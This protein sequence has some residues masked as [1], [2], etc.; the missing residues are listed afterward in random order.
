MSKSLNGI[1]VLDL[2]RIVSAPWCA[3]TLGD[4]G[5]DVIKI[6]RPGRGDDLRTY[7]PSFAHDAQGNPTPES[8]HYLCSN[9]NK[10]SVTIDISKPA[11]QE[12]IRRLA[13]NSDVLIENYKVGDL[14]RYGI[15]YE[16][17]RAVNPNLIY[18]SITGFGQDGPYAKQPGYD[19]AFQG[20]SG[21]M[22]VTGEPQGQPQRVGVFI[23]DEMTGLY[24]AI[25]IL[26]ALRH[27]DAG[28]GGQYIDLA[29][30]DVAVAAM[31]PRTI[32]WTLE[33]KVPERLGT[34]SPGSAPAQ[35]FACADGFLNIQ[36][37]AEPDYRKLCDVLEL[38][39]LK[40]DARFAI[41]KDRVTH[42]EILI[43]LLEQRIRQWPAKE[44]HRKLVERGV[45]A[46]P[47]YQACD[48]VEDPQVK[49]RELHLE[50]PHPTVGK[51][52]LTASPIRLSSTPV[53]V[54]NA[55]PT[56]GQHT[57]EVLSRELGF[58]EERIAELR[59]TGIV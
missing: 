37:G 50:V 14:A 19:A 40:E 8:G 15:D 49:H 47:I 59:N 42:Q 7:G 4:L 41:R 18:C 35:V 51:V 56:I 21:M 33:G 27:R 1:R 11:G 10:R 25:A 24:A 38:P 23:V 3:Q 58:S 48:M 39:E 31:A 12:I 55:P 46:S 6:E 29:L 52:P 34:R 22:A 13:A 16:S 30:L 44:L 36:A 43:P 32:E 28:G 2:G 9:R 45:V 26:A 20:M 53:D 54:Y 5:A 17:L 57:V